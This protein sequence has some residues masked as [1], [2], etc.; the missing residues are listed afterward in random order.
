MRDVEIRE[1]GDG[2]E[3]L[4]ERLD[5]DEPAQAPL[6]PEAA[7]RLLADG[8]THLWVAFEGEEPVGMLLAYELLRWHGDPSLVHVYELGVAPSHHRRGIGRALWDALA[9]RFPG[10]EVY[11]LT[12]ESNAGARAFYEAV[13]LAEPGERVVE[14]DGRL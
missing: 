9:A 8:R 5:F 13:G 3:A 14:Y 1:L 11:V 4:L 6:A 7:A 12:E 2:D 10:V